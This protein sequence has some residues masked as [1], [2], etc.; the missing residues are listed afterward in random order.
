[1]PDKSGM[2][3]LTLP[4]DRIAVFKRLNEEFKKNY[5]RDADYTCF[6]PGRLNII[7]EHIDYCGGMVMPAAIDM[8]T[9]AVAAV[10]NRKEFRLRSLNFPETGSVSLSGADY[11]Q[12]DG[13]LNYPKGI[14]YLLEKQFPGFA[15]EGAD[16]LLYGTLPVGAGLSSSASLLLAVLSLLKEIYTVRFSDNSLEDMRETAFFAKRTE[17]EYIGL[18][19]GIMDQGSVVFGRKDCLMLMDCSR[20]NVEYIPFRS[21]K[22]SLII[23]NTNKSRSLADS[24][25]NIRKAESEQALSDVRS[26][27]PLKDLCGLPASENKTALALIKDETVQTPRAHILTENNRVFRAKE[28]LTAASAAVSATENLYIMVP[29]GPGGG[30][31]QLGRAVDENLKKA[32]LIKNSTY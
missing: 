10:N 30:W 14:I 20:L 7:G 28:A 26:K 21:G 8:G 4:E 29:A 16:I 5:S 9:Y 13:W 15:Q 19:C 32:G 2:Y 22:Y 17:N 12:K 23:A 18:N 27:Y 6:S 31:D 11:Q 24:K 25:Y 3:T 1:M